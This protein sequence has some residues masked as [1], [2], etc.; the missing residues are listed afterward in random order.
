MTYTDPINDTVDACDFDNTDPVQAQTYLDQAINDWVTANQG[1]FAANGG[2][3]P[4]VTNDYIAQ[5][6][7]FCAG[8]NTTITWT[9]EDICESLIDT[10]SC[11][12]TPLTPFPC[13]DPLNET[14]NA[15]DFANTDPLHA[16]TDLDQAIKQWVTTTYRPYATKRGT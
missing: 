15:C 9:I 6:I 12:R 8:G 11:R 3:S 14:M 4:I 13:T 1:A 10:G 2:C 7:D 5:S 16:P